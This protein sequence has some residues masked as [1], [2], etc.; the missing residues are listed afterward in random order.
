MPLGRLK[1]LRSPPAVVLPASGVALCLRVLPCPLPIV[2]VG[3]EWR[4]GYHSARVQCV[5]GQDLH[6]GVPFAAP[7]SP[8]GD[9]GG[10]HHDSE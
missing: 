1:E 10:D 3:D 8:T 2:H 9:V 5:G 7:L 6:G 4:A